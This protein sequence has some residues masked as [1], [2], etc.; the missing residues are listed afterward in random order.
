MVAPSR[1]WGGGRSWTPAI[2]WHHEAR[3]ALRGPP[4]SSTS[5]QA[6]FPSSPCTTWLLSS[7][8]I[9]LGLPSS[10]T[11]STRQDLGSWVPTAPETMLSVWMSEQAV[12]M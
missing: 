10:F 8:A 7:S 3:E 9:G 11:S 12:W 5:S 6:R 2:G 1:M 4:T